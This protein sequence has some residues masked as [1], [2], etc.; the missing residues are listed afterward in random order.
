MK[1][2]YSPAQQEQNAL[3]K[4]VKHQD[5][6]VA[7][8]GVAQWIECQPANQKVAVR[9]H[10]WVEGQVPNWGRARGNWSMSERYMDVSLLLFLPP[11]LSL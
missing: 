2:F 1:S 6:P 5:N 11:F 4:C 7:L 3:F 9:A 10:A 8:D